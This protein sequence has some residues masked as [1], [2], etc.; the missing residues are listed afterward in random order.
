MSVARDVTVWSAAAAPLASGG[1]NCS[2][3][4]GLSFSWR[5]DQWGYGVPLTAANQPFSATL[6]LP[7]R[8]LVP[9]LP[10]R[11]VIQARASRPAAP[12]RCSRRL[13]LGC[14]A[15]PVAHARLL[16]SPT[17]LPDRSATSSIPTPTSAASPPLRSSRCN[18]R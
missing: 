5:G 16:P 12:R 8:S 13:R 9:G 7:A 10:A 2:T 4:G 6:L 11:F 3:G 14:C 15:P 17:F 1:F 18:R